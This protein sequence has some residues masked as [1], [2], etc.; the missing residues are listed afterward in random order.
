MLHGGFIVYTKENKTA[1]VGVPSDLLER[2][3]AVSAEVAQ[4]MASGGLKRCPASIVVSITGVAGPDPDEDGNPVGLVFVGVAT[5]DGR[6][7]T[8]RHDLGEQDKD[9]L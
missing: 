2:Y 5:S 7:K 8:L 1:S 9:A 4:A 6:T 3:T